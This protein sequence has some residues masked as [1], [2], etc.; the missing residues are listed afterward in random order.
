MCPSSSLSNLF[1]RSSPLLVCILYPHHHI[2]LLTIS[3]YAEILKKG[4]L[5]SNTSSS[6]LC[7]TRPQSQLTLNNNQIQRQQQFF[8]IDHQSSFTSRKNSLLF[9][10]L[11]GA[12]LM[13]S[14]FCALTL[15]TAFFAMP[16]TKVLH[17]NHPN[18]WRHLHIHPNNH[19]VLSNKEA[20]SN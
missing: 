15:I 11:G 2:F 10:G 4:T 18:R 17:L 9:P 20:R 1:R 13:Y 5:Y 14:G 16:E 7:I 19:N 6:N 12:F 3:I 8:L